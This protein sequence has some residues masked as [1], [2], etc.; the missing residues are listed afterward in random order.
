MRGALHQAAGDGKGRGGECAGGLQLAGARERRSGGARLEWDGRVRRKTC[1]RR[2]GRLTIQGISTDQ[3]ISTEWFERRGWGGLCRRL[4][5]QGI[6]TGWFE[7]HGRAGFCRRL[8]V[9]GISTGWFEWRGWGG[10][11]RRRTVQGISTG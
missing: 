1:R 10:L 9:Q 7:R 8:T 11:C 4:T 5:V 3:G 2:D 6:S